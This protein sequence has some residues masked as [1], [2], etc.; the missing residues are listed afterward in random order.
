M[1]P[2]G[3][4]WAF[5]LCGQLVNFANCAAI[6]WR[7]SPNFEYC[8]DHHHPQCHTACDQATFGCV[9]V[10]TQQ[11]NQQPCSIKLFSR[12]RL[13]PPWGAAA[14]VAQSAP[15]IPA[16]GCWCRP[17]QPSQSQDQSRLSNRPR[18][19]RWHPSSWYG[20]NPQQQ[21]WIAAAPALPHSLTPYLS[22]HAAIGS[23]THM[24]MPHRRR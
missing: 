18:Q 20:P 3:R 1:C 8:L 2:G 16:A 10:N 14:L 12:G 23:H 13:A 5:L 21:P 7:K 4:G 19:Q 9:V 11:Q 15:S 22:L 17:M 6:I 24:H